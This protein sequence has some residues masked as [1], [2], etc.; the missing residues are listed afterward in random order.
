[1]LINNND[2]L[3]RIAEELYN[4]DI[5][6]CKENNLSVDDKDKAGKDLRRNS[7]GYYS[8][9]SEQGT[10]V[11]AGN[12]K[13]VCLTNKTNSTVTKK[14]SI[15]SKPEFAHVKSK[16]DTGLGLKKA[17]SLAGSQYRTREPLSSLHQKK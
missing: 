13:R 1:M 14:D 3:V 5:E 6:K 4:K 17:T 16:V 11:Q 8:N 9:T 15:N 10:A 7:S 12:G 2:E